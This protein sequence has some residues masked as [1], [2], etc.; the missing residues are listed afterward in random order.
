MFWFYL[1][2]WYGLFESFA[3]NSNFGCK[4]SRS[5]YIVY[6]CLKDFEPKLCLII[7]FLSLGGSTSQKSC[8]LH[9]LSCF[10]NALS[11]QNECKQ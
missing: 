1:D 2:V 8:S 9:S 4:H 10:S 7:S 5:K 11:I 6:G 3:H